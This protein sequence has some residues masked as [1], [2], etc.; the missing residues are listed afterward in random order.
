MDA[1]WTC[2]SLHKIE[3]SQWIFSLAVFLDFLHFYIIEKIQL[4]FKLVQLE[5]KLL[6]LELKHLQLVL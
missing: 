2:Q 5:L 6:Q 1:A 4:E 3:N